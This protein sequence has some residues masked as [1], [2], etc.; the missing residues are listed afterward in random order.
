MTVTKGAFIESLMT[1]KNRMKEL[2]AEI[3]KLQELGNNMNWLIM[4]GWIS[5]IVVW[6]IWL[7]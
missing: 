1:D 3:K 6:M 4:P 5:L 7:R 2:A